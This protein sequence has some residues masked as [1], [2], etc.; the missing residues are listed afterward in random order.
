MR[1][2]LFSHIKSALILADKVN[3][4]ERLTELAID[5]TPDGRIECDTRW[6]EQDPKDYDFAAFLRRTRP[7]KK[8]D[9]ASCHSSDNLARFCQ[10]AVA[11]V[12]LKTALTLSDPKRGSAP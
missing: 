9:P 11:D 1:K 6:S 10:E 4:G 7:K 3:F 12:S 5:V 8:R 2:P